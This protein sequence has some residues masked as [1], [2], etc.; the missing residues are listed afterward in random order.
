LILGNPGVG[1]SSIT[2]LIAR[3][4]GAGYLDFLQDDL[5][6]KDLSARSFAQATPQRLPG[7]L[8]ALKAQGAIRG[9][10]REIARRTF[11][12]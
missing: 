2:K 11:F 10:V 12:W 9:G 3:F 5:E 1:K 6:L 7:E 8:N 4:L